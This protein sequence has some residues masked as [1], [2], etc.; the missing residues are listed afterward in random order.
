M[1][2]RL[3]LPGLVWR[4]TCVGAPKADILCNS[5]VFGEHITCMELVSLNQGSWWYFNKVIC[6]NMI[7]FICTPTEISNC[8]S[9]WCINN[10]SSSLVTNLQFY[11]D[12]S[13]VSYL[14]FPYFL[15][16]IYLHSFLNCFYLVHAEYTCISMYSM[17]HP[18]GAYHFGAVLAL[19]LECP[20]PHRGLSWLY[21]IWI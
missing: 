4:L 7:Q 11:I 14:Y 10:I 17:L 18:W 8:F 1:V 21:G 2:N 9:L 15:Y 16:L 12:L 3:T 5:M 19:E 20:D 13:H 6:P